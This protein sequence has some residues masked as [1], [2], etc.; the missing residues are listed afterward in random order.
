MAL[1][2]MREPAGPDDDISWIQRQQGTQNRGRGHVQPATEGSLDGAPSRRDNIPALPG[3]VRSV[4]HADAGDQDFRTGGALAFVGIAVEARAAHEGCWLDR[5]ALRAAAACVAL[6]GRTEDEA[7]LRDARHLTKPGQD[8]GPG[9]RV[10]A[11]WQRVAGRPSLLA[12][13]E[14]LVATIQHLGFRDSRLLLEVVRLARDLAERTL[15]PLAAVVDMIALGQKRCP[16]LPALPLLLADS[17]LAE[18]LHWPT[19]VPLLA[20]GLGGHPFRPRTSS[21]WPT[22]CLPALRRGCVTAWA[23]HQE[24]GRQAETLLAVRGRLRSKMSGGVV[25]RL[26]TTDAL[27]PAR[28]PGTG[29]DRAGRRLFDRLVALGAVRELT[30]RT[31]FR[32]YGL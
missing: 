22:A 21:D 27:S 2:P 32:L 7:A 11:L 9:G 12:E 8:P 31:S 14:A 5:L 20:V 16:G 19:V 29:S 25:E 4:G 30:G 24:I 26:L 10:F 13:P 3:W 15:S 28:L 6:E 1:T 18:R 23:L 17:I